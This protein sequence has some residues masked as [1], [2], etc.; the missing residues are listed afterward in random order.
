VE[1]G[2]LSRLF[3]HLLKSKRFSEALIGVKCYK[4]HQAILN[5]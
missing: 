2:R 5:N 1:V 3:I 4:K